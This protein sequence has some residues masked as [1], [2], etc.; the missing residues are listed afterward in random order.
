MADHEIIYRVNSAGIE[1]VWIGT[2]KAH[3]INIRNI[4]ET[5]DRDVITMEQSKPAD[6]EEFRDC[7]HRYLQEHAYV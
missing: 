6:F 1:F 4:G 2:E 3:T 7:V 5:Q